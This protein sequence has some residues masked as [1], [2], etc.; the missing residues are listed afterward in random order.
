MS[1]GV[2]GG[3]M[4][5]VEHVHEHGLA[6]ALALA[7][8]GHALALALPGTLPVP[9][10]PGLSVSTAVLPRALPLHHDVAPVLRA[11]LRGILRAVLL[12]K[13]R[14]RRS[15]SFDLD[16]GVCFALALAHDDLG[17]FL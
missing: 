10:R 14:R 7:H 11:V 6:L 3:V 12:R 8:A 16:V 9:F 4:H 13:L 17:P 2:V 1:T 5:L 15:L